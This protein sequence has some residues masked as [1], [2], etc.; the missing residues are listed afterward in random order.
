MCTVRVGSGLG[1]G[2]GVRVRTGGGRELSSPQAHGGPPISTGLE[3]CTSNGQAGPSSVLP[4]S[5]EGGEVPAVC[6]Q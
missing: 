2:I 5:I 6:E 4:P 1:V 3:V